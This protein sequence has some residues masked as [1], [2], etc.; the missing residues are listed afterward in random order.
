MV[1][2]KLLIVAGEASGD[3][4]GSNLIISILRIDPSVKTYGIGGIRMTSLGFQSVFD[5]ANLAVVGLTE[6]ISKF[7]VIKSAFDKLKDTIDKDRPDLVVLIDYPDFNL[8]FAKKVK[9]RGIP[10]IYYISPQVWAW[11]KG[12]VKKIAKLVDKMLVIFQFEE[13]I[14]KDAGV[15]V[16][17]VGHPLVDEVKCGLSRIEARQVLGIDKD[18][19]VVAIAPGSRTSEISRLM[20][21]ILDAA[22]IIK[23]EIP[24]AMFILPLAGTLE[25]RSVERFFNNKEIPVKIFE[26][27]MYE[28]IAASDAAIV[29][30]GTATLETALLKT[31]MVVVYKVSPVT[32][33]IG[34]VLVNVDNISLVNIIAGRKV[35]PELIQGDANQERI[36][37]EVLNILKNAHISNRMTED[38]KMVREKLG[39]GGASKKSAEIIYRML[40]LK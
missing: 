10:V 17:Y 1:Q 27:R 14:Y 20:P 6:V 2:K 23:R 18:N 25:R 21:V 5:A 15:D 33:W 11:R 19:V 39:K 28:V 22:V 34:K 40:S 31:P 29:A 4:H 32:Y 35:V 12:R 30:S 37:G 38:L 7:P 26:K 16:E 9:K 36:A 24:S 3:L 8:R 13:K